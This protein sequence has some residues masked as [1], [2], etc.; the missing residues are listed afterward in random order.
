MKLESHESAEDKK[1][2]KIVRL[3]SCEEV[4]GE[5]VAADDEK[6]EC[7]VERTVEGEKKTESM[8]FGPGGM[9]IVRR[10]R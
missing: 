9:R 5:I 8:S 1:R 3:D 7:C 4:P 10:G 6:G 2:W